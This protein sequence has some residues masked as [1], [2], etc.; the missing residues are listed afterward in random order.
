[1]TPDNEIIEMASEMVK[2][3]APKPIAG[4]ETAHTVALKQGNADV[5]ENH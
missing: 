5:K 1:V 4:Y 2:Q 3:F